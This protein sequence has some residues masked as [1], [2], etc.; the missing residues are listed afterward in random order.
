[1][2]SSAV[3]RRTGPVFS[4]M[5]SVIAP[6]L[7]AL[8]L[9]PLLLLL[10]ASSAYEQVCVV[11]ALSGVATLARSQR[12][13]VAKAVEMSHPCG[14]RASNPSLVVSARRCCNSRSYAVCGDACAERSR[15]ANVGYALHVSRSSTRSIV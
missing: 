14:R 11:C 10:L 12:A 8:L 6:C 4:T 15:A 5:T 3:R 9:P 7:S 13:A 1:M 2:L